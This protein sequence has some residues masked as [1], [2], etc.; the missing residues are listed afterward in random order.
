MQELPPS[1]IRFPIFTRRRGV[2]SCCGSLSRFL[3]SFQACTLRLFSASVVTGTCS[4]RIEKRI[5]YRFRD[6]LRIFQS[7]RY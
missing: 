2:A 7:N 5:G 1:P 4:Q 3:A 6:L